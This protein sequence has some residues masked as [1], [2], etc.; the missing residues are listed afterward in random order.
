MKLSACLVLILCL[1]ATFIPATAQKTKRKASAPVPGLA[2]LQRMAAR[3]APTPLRVDISRLS[4]GDRQA[5]AKLIE[6]GRLMN[7]VFLKQYWS[8]DLDLY[9]R[10]Q[11][12]TT[13]LGKARLRLFWINK[14]PWS[15]LD[16]YRPFIP[17][18][19][20]EKPPG[21][22]F[23]PEDMTRQ[24]FET[25]VATLPKE[26]QDHAR[27]FFTVIRWKNGTRSASNG[28]LVAVPYSEEYKDNLTRA[29][30][31][32]KE[33]AGLTENASLKNFLNLRADAFLS[34]TYYD[35]DLAWMDL[36]APLDITIGPYETYNDQVFGYKAAF[37][38]YVN[39]R[40]DDETTKFSVL[41]AHLQDIENNLPLDPQYRNPKLGKAAPIRVVDEVLYAGD[42][43]HGIATAAYNLPNDE[44][45]VQ[46]QGSK[47]VMLR[48]VQ[49]AKFR[50]VL[51]PIARR[52]LSSPAMVD[53]NFESF[54]NHIVAHELMHGLGPHQIT[55]DGRDTTVRKELKDL[56]SAIEEAKA[57]ITGLFA[58]QY[59]MDHAR[60]MNLSAVLP[61]DGAAQ[62]QLYTTYLASM[63]RSVRFGLE[64]AHGKGMAVQFN[65]LMDHGA[66][67][68]G[69][70]QTFTLD[71]ERFKQAV[72]DLDHDLLT[73]EAQGDYAAAKKLLD[74]M[75]V[76]RPLM[77]KAFER[78]S[79]I[80]TDIQQIFVT[81]D[82]LAPEQPEPAA[83]TVGKK[84]SHR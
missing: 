23:Y 12:D 39:L 37:E 60:E 10:L 78:L 31:L 81:A 67:T 47:R 62:R 48:N 40:D 49:E 65:Y 17:G 25:W 24:D 80:P 53:V 28:A 50:S 7:P 22:N 29:S 79:E 63:F 59:M 44:R 51:L 70:D 5:L 18:V 8:G 43:N 11:K 52:V 58:L 61:S 4:G 3:F 68:Q 13:P 72:R 16:E 32:L 56:Y 46:Q 38:V 15:A 20:A 36:D 82:E 41:S 69:G 35:S 83:T 73:I 26:D 64:D 54:F 19:P 34:N 77:R 27:S 42:S 1:G 14:G 66:V 57:D 33:A 6:A 71:L 55:V 74:E 75:G 2:E 9:A 84:K 45:I 21:S 30:E 76:V